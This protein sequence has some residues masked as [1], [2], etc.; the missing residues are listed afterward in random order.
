MLGINY[1]FKGKLK[2]GGHIGIDRVLPLFCIHDR[3]R[4]KRAQDYS[5]ELLAKSSPNYAIIDGPGSFE[6]HRATV[7][8]T[9]KAAADRFGG[10]LLLELEELA[11]SGSVDA[12]ESEGHPLRVEISP[13]ESSPALL[14]AIDA[15]SEQMQA[16][17]RERTLTFVRGSPTDPTPALKALTVPGGTSAVFK[18]NLGAITPEAGSPPVFVLQ[19]FGETFQHALF[20]MA[21][22]LIDPG[23]RSKLEY[24]IAL[25]R[26]HL[27]PKVGRIERVLSEVASSFDLL[28]QLTPV[29]GEH[30][31]E[32]FMRSECQQ[33]PRFEY[34]PILIDPDQ[35]KRRIYNLPIEHVEDPAL[36]RILREQREHLDHQL[37]ML[38]HRNTM[39]CRY[40]SLQI[41]G[42]VEDKLY[43]LASAIPEALPFENDAGHIQWLKAADFRALALEELD[44]YKGQDESFDAEIEIRSDVSSLTVAGSKLLVPA[45]LCLTETSSRALLAHEVGTH[46][47][48]FHNGRHQPLE[49]MSTGLAGY[50]QLQEGL[51]VIAE[52]LAGGFT[53]ARLKRIAAR[54]IAVKQLLDGANFIEA[55]REL[56]GKLYLGVRQA[57][58]VTMRVFRGGGL[59]KDAIYLR[60]MLEVL[61]HLA[62][63]QPL[64]LLLLGKFGK[65]HV[66]LV[67]E[68]IKRKL[69]E[70]PALLP[71]V[72]TTSS[73]RLRLAALTG[74]RRSVFDLCERTA[75]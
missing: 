26:R 18:L 52:Y 9:L 17:F 54:V 22:Q 41:Y 34:R 38:E 63:K 47:L 31:F 36:C 42:G 67:D 65:S 64:E 19:E 60:G 23:Q 5:L 15:C 51:A 50:E 7:E 45:T 66:G 49:L 21:W 24:P 33:E 40:T 59:T 30:A 48:T 2:H 72:L 39:K 3:S 1:P 12:D 57:F 68:L 32:D 71:R 62:R 53:N 46:M 28:L 29:N 10:C 61:D 44:Y 74:Q 14:K 4:R 73:G 25:G 13:I 58:F 75:T 20:A 6:E 16:G 35:L 27:S 56:T 8:R 55:F 11:T 70:P 69:L 37:S 43:R